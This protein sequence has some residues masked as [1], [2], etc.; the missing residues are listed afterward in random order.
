MPARY[1]PVPVFSPRRTIF[2]LLGPLLLGPVLL[3]FGCDRTQDEPGDICQRYTIRQRAMLDLELERTLITAA[4]YMT[5]EQVAKTRLST[6]R[7]KDGVERKCRALPAE[8]AACLE[9]LLPV[10]DEYLAAVAQ[11]E[12]AA[13]NKA[14]DEAAGKKLILSCKDALPQLDCR[15][16]ND[17]APLPPEQPE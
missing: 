8:Q 9:P 13:C 4:Q 6:A 16:S 5:P 7:A 15:S 3:S 2:T 12:T 14:A 10:L 11:C 17:C 1:A